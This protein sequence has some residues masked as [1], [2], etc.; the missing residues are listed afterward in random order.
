ME[1]LN[2]IFDEFAKAWPSPVVAREKIADFSGGA[3][4]SKYM[5]N[6]DSQKMGPP[7]IKIGRKVVYPKAQL[8]EFMR[9][10]ATMV[11]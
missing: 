1:T 11:H 10:R 2:E 9:K 5:A 7:R 8:V 3:F 6:L 4:S